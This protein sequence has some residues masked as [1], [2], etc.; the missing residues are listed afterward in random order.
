MA[1]LD[2]FR[3]PI[4]SYPRALFGYIVARVLPSPSVGAEV[5]GEWQLKALQPG[6]SS[7]P[8]RSAIASRLDAQVAQR[9]PVTLQLVPKATRLITRDMEIELI[10]HMHERCALS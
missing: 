5:A 6:N 4:P 3:P 9:A 1:Q 10:N 8:Q 7:R 2:A